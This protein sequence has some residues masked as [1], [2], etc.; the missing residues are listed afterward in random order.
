MC[1]G[2]NGKT[3]AAW[4]VAYKPGVDELRDSAPFEIVKQ[5]HRIGANVQL[6]DPMTNERARKELPDIRYMANPVEAATGADLVLHLTDW[7][8]FA[9]QDPAQLANT[10]RQRVIIDTRHTLDPKRWKSAGWRYRAI[11]HPQDC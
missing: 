11:G 8:E 3:I 5:L 6:Y 2:A 4:G 10:V 1:G 7:D 9:R